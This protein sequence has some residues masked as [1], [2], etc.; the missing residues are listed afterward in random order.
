M[1]TSGTPKSATLYESAKHVMPAGNTRHTVF[2]T[3]HQV[4][5]ERGEG[6]RIIDIDG[7][8]R[9]DAVGNFTSLIHG[10]GCEAIKAAAREQLEKGF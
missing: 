1:N 5:A 2:G 3:P 6:C 8:S 7:N 9:I 10:Y 4:Y